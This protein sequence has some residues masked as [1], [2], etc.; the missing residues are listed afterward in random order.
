MR[1]DP[2]EEARKESFAALEQAVSLLSGDRLTPADVADVAVQAGSLLAEGKGRWVALPGRIAGGREREMIARILPL[3]P[4]NAPSRPRREESLYLQAALRL[5]VKDPV[6]GSAAREFLEKYPASPLSAEIG[7]RLGLEALLA[8]DTGGAVARYRAAA[9]TGDPEAAAVGRYMLGWIRFR[10]RDIDGTVRE[11]SPVLSDPSFSC[12]DLSPFEQEVLSL[13][14][15][16]WKESPPERLDSYP[17]VKAGTCGGKVLLTALSEAEEMRGEASRAAK[18]R[19]VASR[20]FPSDEG[21]GGPRDED[22]GGAPPRRPGPGGARPRPHASREIRPG[23]RL[24][25]VAARSRAGE[26]RGGAG[27]DAEDPLRE[28][29]RRRDPLGRTVGHVLGG[30]GDGR[31]FRYERRRTVG[32]GRRTAPEVGDR[33]PPIGGP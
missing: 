3:L 20:R 33:A 15:R 23:F 30:D 9:E 12:G 8:G 2:R 16:A 17:P 32:R 22:G 18:V 24:G 13:S 5:A 29:V 14:V 26:G 28:E 4:A 25:A 27:R 31:I 7:V 11:L 1:Q 19:D 10:D 6:A 21:R